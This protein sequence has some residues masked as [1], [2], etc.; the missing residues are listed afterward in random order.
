MEDGQSVGP[1]CP[2]GR[3]SQL[4]GCV[5]AEAAQTGR[6]EG[7]AAGLCPVAAGADAVAEHEA[8]GCPSSC[9]VSRCVGRRLGGWEGSDEVLRARGSAEEEQEPRTLQIGEARQLSKEG[10]L[11]FEAGLA[12]ARDEG[13][14]ADRSAERNEPALWLRL[15]A[16]P[17]VRAEGLDARRGWPARAVVDAGLAAVGSNAS[18]DLHRTCD[19]VEDSA[20]PLWGGDNVEVVQ[21][22]RQEFAL[23]QGGSSSV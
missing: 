2:V 8:E 12:S 22:G 15:V 1:G 14:R 23:E 20:G 17:G 6:E 19:G 3:R 10:L 13:R 4:F 21:V 7:Q 18:M 16:A 9:I 5:E 11:G